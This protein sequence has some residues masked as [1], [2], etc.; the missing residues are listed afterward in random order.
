MVWHYFQVGDRIISAVDCPCNN[1]DIKI[2]DTGVVCVIETSEFGPDWRGVGVRWDKCVGGHD[3]D[4]NCDFG[5]G[6]Y[7]YSDE[8]ELQQPDMIPD[9]DEVDAFLRDMG[10]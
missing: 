8:I 5:F 4:G 9:E 1:E 7:V 2:G 3:C 6:W 10:A